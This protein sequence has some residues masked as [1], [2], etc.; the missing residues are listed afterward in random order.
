MQLGIAA[1]AQAD[2]LNLK[3]SAPVKVSGQIESTQVLEQNKSCRVI[4]P[5]SFNQLNAQIPQGSRKLSFDDSPVISEQQTVLQGNVTLKER[6]FSLSAETIVL[7]HQT[8]QV[9]ASGGVKIE[10]SASTFSSNDLI[11]DSQGKFELNSAEFELV[12]SGAHG[13]AGKISQSNVKDT[14]LQN[15]TYT[16][17]EKGSEDWYLQMGELNI[18]HLSGRAEA[19]G[20]K[21]KVNDIPVFYLPYFTFPIDDRRQSGLLFPALKN[22]DKNGIDYTQPIYWNI[23][24][25]F[26]A[27]FAP[28]WIEKRGSQLGTELR[29]LTE[30]SYSIWDFEYLDDDEVV[31]QQLSDAS[32]DVAH[33]DVRRWLSKFKSEAKF[34]QNWQLSIDSTRVSDGD[35]FRDYGS[36]LESSNATLLKNETLLSYADNIW[37]LN[38]FARADQ[39]LIGLSTYRYSPSVT[40][41]ADHMAYGLR[42]QL[43]TE[44]TEFTHS[45]VGQ[46]ETTRAHIQPSI[47]IPL[48]SSWGFAIPKVSWLSTQFEQVDKVLNAS[49]TIE[50]ELPIYSFDAG[51]HFEKTYNST[52]RQLTHLVSPRLF[53]SYVPYEKQ[54]NIQL[55]DSSEPLFGFGQLWRENRFTG[56]DRVGDTNH[57][58]VAIANT[59]IDDQ[60]GRQVFYANI[61]K[62]AYFEDRRVQLNGESWRTAEASPWLLETEFNIGNSFS[63]QSL[64]EWEQEADK[65]NQSYAKL[66]FEPKANHIVNLT[67]RYRDTNGLQAD[68]TDLSFA[69]PINER[70]RLVGRWYNDL[71]REQTIESLAG[72]E[73]E[74]CC[75][76]VRIVAQKYLSTQF[77]SFGAIIP[78][79]DEYTSGI[80]LQ[81]VFKGLGSAGG[82]GLGRVLESS[83]YGYRD[84]LSS[85]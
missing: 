17:C 13:K 27:T 65:V 41:E 26:D 18:N 57:V 24:P 55:L 85:F 19:Y 15:L 68:E 71:A 20:T 29:W 48:T 47:S 23:A 44:W 37:D 36:G 33:L 14:Q 81:F 84:P 82:S 69:W 42:W 49:T 73:Y 21:L 77:D 10:S 4:K 5:R 39:S 45:D 2:P 7:S 34:N 8:E 35:Y 6:D 22:S 70:W 32:L 31:A 80:Q 11:L 51:L 74:S 38:L 3:E 16:T 9:K 40:A 54:D 79:S 12:K 60:S 52:H 53:Y 75:W 50:R 56:I 63:F 67:H 28:R 62:R 64:I 1:S 66:K 58:S 78:S 61:G 30:K 83:I 46:I 76:A 72:I 59:V 43:S 25:A